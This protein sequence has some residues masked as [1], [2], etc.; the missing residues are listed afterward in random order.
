MISEKT[1]KYKEHVA[2]KKKVKQG[3]ARALKVEKRKVAKA[4]PSSTS[5]KATAAKNVEEKDH[6]DEDETED[7]AKLRTKLRKDATPP[8]GKGNLSKSSPLTTPEAQRL[9]PIPESIFDK[10]MQ[11]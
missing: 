5:G 9:P 8:K 4:S 1:T 3:A 7:R 11:I 2:E 6:D 10:F